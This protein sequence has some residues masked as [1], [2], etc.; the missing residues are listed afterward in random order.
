MPCDRCKMSYPAELLNSLFVSGSGYTKPLCGI[1]ALEVSNEA[2]GVTHTK[3]DGEM[4]EDLR[5]RAIRWRKK[6]G[7]H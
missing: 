1:C 7:K 5:Q 6:M 4:A 2:L 3:F